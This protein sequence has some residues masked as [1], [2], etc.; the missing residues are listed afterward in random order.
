[1]YEVVAEAKSGESVPEEMESEVRLASATVK[2]T[3][4]DAT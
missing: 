4:V 3:G 1:V 2:V